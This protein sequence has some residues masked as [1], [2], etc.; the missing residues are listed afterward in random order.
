VQQETQIDRRRGG[1]RNGHEHR[2][3][4]PDVF[5]AGRRS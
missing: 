5:G 4:L 1:R 3:I 2:F